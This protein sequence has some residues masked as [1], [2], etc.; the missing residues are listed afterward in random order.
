MDAISEREGKPMVSSDQ[1]IS[2]YDCNHSNAIKW[3]DY[4]NK[5]MDDYEINTPLRTC[6]FIAQI[7]HESGRLQFTR[8][9]A[10]GDAYEGRKDLGN[11]EPGDGRKYKGRGL[12]Q[13][14]G[15]ANYQKYGDLLNID[16]INN[17][18]WLEIGPYAATSA[19]LFW[20]LHGLNDLADN[21]DLIRITKRI[22]GGTNGL[23]DR[24]GL[25]DSAKK[26]LM[27]EPI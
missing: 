27:D 7:G 5:A 2:I 19:A 6:H 10:S 13:I 16:L 15:R 20:Q 4:I 9:L 25:L 26:E 24:Q 14:T 23:Q 3:V 22:N 12:I 1:L 17:P 18:T 11:T 8:E 21:D